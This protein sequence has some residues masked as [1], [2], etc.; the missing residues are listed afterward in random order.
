MARAVEAALEAR[1]AQGAL[2]AAEEETGVARRTVASA[3]AAV[4]AE[5]DEDG[6]EAWPDLPPEGIHAAARVGEAVTVGGAAGAEANACNAR[7]D[8]TGQS[9]GGGAASSSS[10][11]PPPAA[12]TAVDEPAVVAFPPALIERVPAAR[13]YSIIDMTGPH[14]W[15]R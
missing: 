6:G 14:A 12:S 10:G 4:G 7:A 11:P 1:K 5:A 2:A 15:G 9:G 13:N 3:E 8:S